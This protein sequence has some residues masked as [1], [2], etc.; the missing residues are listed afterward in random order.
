MEWQTKDGVIKKL[1][2]VG[3]FKLCWTCEHPTPKEKTCGTCV[4]CCSMS[5]ALWRLSKEP[6]PKKLTKKD[7]IKISSDI[8]KKQAEI[9]L[10]ASGY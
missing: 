1:K 4:P 7:A 9:K 10:V 8:S 2:E 5:S 6:K 3:L